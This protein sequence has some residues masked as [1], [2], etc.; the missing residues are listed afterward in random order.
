[1]DDTV[2]LLNDTAVPFTAEIPALSANHTLRN[3]SHRKDAKL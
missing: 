3:S 2:A 1:M